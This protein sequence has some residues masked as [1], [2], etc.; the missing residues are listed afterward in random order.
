MYQ[1][2]IYI[3]NV[4][5]IFQMAIKYISIFPST[6]VRPSKNYL[7]RDF[8]FENKPSGN[9]TQQGCQ[10]A[11]FQNKNPNLGNFWGLWQWKM[12]LYFMA[13]GS[14]LRQLG[15]VCGHLVYFMVIWHTFSH[16]ASKIWQPCCP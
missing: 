5:K 15:L 11:Y 13:I 14:I 7:N 3:P 8:G 16:V 2:V 1:M 12:L 6:Y 4:L 9:T 10:M